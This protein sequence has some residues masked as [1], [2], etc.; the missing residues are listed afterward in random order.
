M[1]AQTHQDRAISPRMSQVIDRDALAGYLYVQVADHLAQRIATGELAMGTGLPSELK[2]AREYGV[3]LGTMRH[4]T[5]VLR[6]RGLVVTVQSKGTFVVAQPDVD[7]ND[8]RREDEPEAG[9][10]LPCGSSTP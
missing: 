10:R 6:K 9:R 1:F 5:Q 8:D 4:A 2:L 7:T 3:S